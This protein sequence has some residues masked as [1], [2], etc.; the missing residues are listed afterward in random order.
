[1]HINFFGAAEE[2]TGSCY[3][4]ES[5]GFRLLIDCGL[6]QGHGDL[7]QLNYEEFPFQ[8]STIDAMILTHA[9]TDHSGLIPKLIT[10]GF[11]GKIWATNETIQLCS[12]MLPDSGH[13]QEMDIERKNRQRRRSG[14]PELSPIYTVKDA[15]DALSNF[16]VV[17]Y[18]QKVQLSSTIQFELFDAG[19]ILG[20][21]HAVLTITENNTPTKYIFSGDI[22]T[23]N[24]PFVANPTI[25]TEG[26]VVIMETTYGDRLHADKSR[27][28]E[29]L[30]EVIR[31]TYSVGGNLIIPAFAINRTQDLLYYIRTLQANGEIPTIPVYIDSPLAIAATKIFT[32][33]TENFDEET[34]L[35]IEQGENPLQIP[36]LHF[37]E[38]ADDSKA[39]N[40]IPGGVI[41]LAASGMADAGRIRHHLK[42]NLWRKNAT[43]LFVGY[44]A[45]GTLGR[46]LLEGA[47]HVTIYGEEITVN[48][49]I[50]Q[51]DG[52]SAHADQA[53]LLG[54]IEH[55]AKVAKHLILVHGEPKAQNI[56]AEKI[57]EMYGKNVLIPQLGE[58]FTFTETELLRYPPEKPWLVP[59]TE[60]IETENAMPTV[61]KP[62]EREALLDSLSKLTYPKFSDKRVSK[63]QIN[64]SYARLQ[65][66]LKELIDQGQ[67]TRRLDKVLHILN[68]LTS[69][70]D[71]Q[72]KEEDNQ[73]RR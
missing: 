48:A 18:Q 8:P 35:L 9:H 54:W 55:L 67:H 71:I 30:A 43:V 40:E 25:L 44:Q 37:S 32:E 45:E 5:E 16:S 62:E 39:L 42:H 13:I 20:S 28:L 57:K 38:T 69:W 46:L 11:R 17:D 41:I 3:L 50:A 49:R 52:L 29:Q 33:N 26:D 36:N 72:I 58:R 22:G 51:I 2:V 1:M 65:H 73:P 64:R 14:L 15:T 56:L 66:H 10:H 60:E 63:S 31:S 24:K 12:V 27:Q 34:R 59:D 7:K 47:P 61:M 21:A 53:E 19:H 70:I 4:V 6:F 68:T 23:A